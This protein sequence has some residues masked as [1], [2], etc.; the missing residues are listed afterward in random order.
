MRAVR[1]GLFAALVCA[2]CAGGT[3]QAREESP[4]KDIAAAPS[5]APLPAPHG[6]RVVDIKG[7]IQRQL[8]DKLRGALANV[9]PARFPAGALVLLDSPGGD[10]LVALEAGR[11]LRAAKAQV[12][13]QHRCESA[14]VF[15][16]A[17]G[18]LRGAPADAVIRI[19]QPRLT[20]F[21]KG[22]GMVDLDPASN[23]K[24][25]L[26]LET[27]NRRTREY[28]HEMGMP[29][30]L[31]GAM[32]AAPSREP[33]LLNASELA[34][35]GL[36][37]FDPAYRET[38]AAEGAKVYGITAEEFVKRSLRVAGLC[39]A[40]STLPDEIVRCYRRVLQTGE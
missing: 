10:G 17:G 20:V 26:A 39:V 4:P 15:V 2:L 29:D 13:V 27:A 37:G 12:F 19:H 28:L 8:L 7:P 14:C 35:F 1:R 36:A 16:L 11:L 33:R 25:L 40:G 21:V 18:V 6:V 31:F 24:A 5:S 34:G 23:P 3:L 22:I 9:D 38:R 30:D 32:M